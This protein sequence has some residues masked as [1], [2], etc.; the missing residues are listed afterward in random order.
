MLASAV[1]RLPIIRSVVAAKER[2]T[3]RELEESMA[4]QSD[5]TAIREL[6]PHGMPESEL[7][8][9][10]KKKVRGSTHVMRSLCL[11]EQWFHV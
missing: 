11:V 8:E 1:F 7:R 9:L 10:L 2:Q 4:R 5:P 6:P 3:V